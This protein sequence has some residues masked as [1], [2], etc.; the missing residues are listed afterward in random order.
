M[1]VEKEVDYEVRLSGT[2]RVTARRYSSTAV[3]QEASEGI[4]QP[5]ATRLLLEL[6]EVL[7]EFIPPSQARFIPDSRVG[8]ISI[9]IDGQETS[10][11]LLVDEGQARQHGAA[12]SPRAAAAVDKLVQL[13]KRIFEL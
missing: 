11:F 4:P 8:R 2:G 5:D 1:P 9:S 10:L 13:H 12:L 6:A 7:S 3:M